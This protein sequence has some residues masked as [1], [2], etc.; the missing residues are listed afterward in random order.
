MKKTKGLYTIKRYMMKPYIMISFVIL[1][2]VISA[3]ASS[4]PF[5]FEP[6]HRIVKQVFCMSC[7]AEEF[8]DLKLGTHIKMMSSVQNRALYDYVELY[9]NVSETYKTLVGACYSCHVAYENFN[10]FGLTDPFVFNG[11]NGIINAQYGKIVSWPWPIGNHAVEYFSSGNVAISAELEVLSVYPANVAVGSTLKIMLSNYSGQQPVNP[12]C[13]CYQTLYQGDTQVVTVNNM[14]ADYFNILLLMD[15]AWNNAT[16][17]LRV[18][19]TDK[20]NES[21]IITANNSPFL[22]NI[23][24]DIS[25]ISYFKTNDTYKAVRLDAIWNVWKGYSVNGNIASSEII[26]TNTTN[27]WTSS[28]TCSAPDVM[29]HINQKVTS[30]GLSDGMNPEKSFYLHEM[31]AVTSKQCKICHLRYLYG[32]E[33]PIDVP[34]IPGLPGTGGSGGAQLYDTYCASCHGP[35]AS[36]SMGGTVSQITAGI[37]NV[38]GMTSCCS[39]LTSAQ[40]QSISDAI[41]SAN[42]PIPGPT[43]VPPPGDIGTP[44]PNPTFKFIAWGDTKGGVNVLEAESKSIVSKNPSFT[45]YAG[46][47]CDSGP[48]TTCFNERKDAF[49]GDSTGATSNGIFDKTFAIRGNHDSSGSVWQAGFNFNNVANTIGATNYVAQTPE[50][51]YSF[52]Y[53]NSHFV[54]IDNVC[55]NLNNCAGDITTAQI[56][57][58]D[59]DL[60]NAE[61]RGMKH[62][63]LFWHGPAYPVDGHCCGGISSAMIT[64]LNKHPIV[65]AGFF[66][67]EHVV[68]YTHLD[69]NTNPGLS[70]SFEQVISGGSGAG[71]YGIN[72][73]RTIDYY[74]GQTFGYTMI[75]V[76]GND[77]D[78]SFYKEDGTRTKTLSFTETGTCQ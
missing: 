65:S 41:L 17:N 33:I 16:V 49:N 54:G 3:I 45:L 57:W 31:E 43:S 26:E 68:E 18:Y 11:P 7:H 9:G 4:L 48:S 53:D 30:V 64:V 38:A 55:G 21:F 8:E 2:L 63:F 61:N 27:G 66:G 72:S 42:T 1:L 75:G 67:H 10:K 23:P 32:L 74:L 69:S 37:A 71:L 39:T 15:G 40:I 62:A 13:D 50:M 47:L 60:T 35:I 25:G 76:S 24:T 44:M 51:T 12:T 29:C 46:D 59:Q 58:L 19:G 78:I 5:R 20:G 52:D 6:T 36:F 14:T 22:Y 70:C 56:N 77:F 34:P 73:G 28:Y